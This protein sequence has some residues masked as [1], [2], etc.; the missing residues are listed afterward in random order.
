MK[1]QNTL[2]LLAISI[3]SILLTGCGGDAETLIIEREPIV[4]APADDDHDHDHGDGGGSPTNDVVIESMGRLA[5]T[6][7]ESNSVPLLDIDDGSQLDTFSLSND[8][9]RIY[10]SADNRY[11]VLSAREADTV[12]FLDG[13]LWRED[14]VEH[15]HD[16]EQAP[17]MTDM[18]LTGSRPTHTSAHD[19]KLA[20]FYDGDSDAGIPAS[21]QIITDSD[22]TSESGASASMTYSVNM[23]GAAKTRG[24]YVIA[25]LR[26][27]DAESTSGA[28]ILPD[29]IGIFHQ[30]DDELELE[31]TLDLACPDLHGS[32][33]SHEFDVFGCGDGVLAV[34]QHDDSFEAEKIVNI[35]ALD[36]VRVGTLYGHENSEAFVGVASSRTTGEYTLVTVNPEE[37]EMEVLDWQPVDGATPVSYSF[38]YDG[39]HF[40]ILDSQGQLTLMAVE[41]HDGHTHVEFEE[42]LSITDLD[43]TTMPDGASFAMVAS[44]N[45]N[46]IYVSDP[47]AQHVLQIDVLSMSIEGDMEL[48]FVPSSLVWLGIA[49]E[50]DHNHPE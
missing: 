28:K 35:P 34:H 12:E 25:T 4:E 23:H 17:S 50:E 20:I 1:N 42:R 7:F 29:Q 2:S 19:G 36:G 24:E 14:H 38:T 49:E 43:L 21:V 39:A 15:L 27:D 18:V 41:A 30:H 22:I 11:V 45:D 9:T 33:Q 8:G 6:S 46:H 37:N 26:R 16:Y 5:V 13:G 3:T 10:A 47:M 32:A 31:Q 44:K 48:D 40:V